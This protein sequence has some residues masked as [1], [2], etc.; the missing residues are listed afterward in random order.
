MYPPPSLPPAPPIAMVNKEF[1]LMFTTLMVARFGAF[2]EKFNIRN[3]LKGLRFNGSGFCWIK[4]LKT[5]VAIDFPVNIN[6]P[7]QVWFRVLPLGSLM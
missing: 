4:I 3:D 2:S 6:I 7:I 5:L 1:P